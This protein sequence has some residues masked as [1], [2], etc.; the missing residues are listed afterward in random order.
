MDEK[1]ITLAIESSCDDTGIAILNGQYDLLNSKL[2][3]QIASH[4]Q[5][6]GVV[7]ELASRM[8][9]E[10]ILP[11]LDEVLKSAGITDPKSQIDLIAVTSGPGLMGSLLVGVMAAKGLAQALE[12]PIIG[13]NHLEGHIFANILSNRN[14]C[15]PFL[16]VVVS[17]G[18]TEVILV[19]QLGEYK[20][21][22][23]TRDDA[24][25][26]AYDKVSKVLGLGYPGGPIIDKLAVE[27]SID[28]FTFPTPLSNTNK[29]EFSFSGLKTAVMNAV[30]K[31]NK[32]SEPFNNCDLC[33]SFQK[34]AINSLICKIQLAMVQT[35]VTSLTLS[36]GVA[37]NSALRKELTLL[38][39]KLNWNLFLPP[40]DMCTDNAAMIA[41]AGYCAYKRGIRSD[42]SLSPNPSWEIW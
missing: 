37:A 24:L 40:K 19:K 26:E 32:L 9:Q 34:A 7:P 8:H 20:L 36:G 28:S 21:I 13:V 15:P 42:L 38:S 29:V 27:G 18:H 1:F 35:Q 14:L 33:A 41:A 12:K 2:A 17:G 3:S 23:S 31:K 4:S 30:Q 22:G 5:Y 16:S 6:G 10:A 11:L 39:E 25:G